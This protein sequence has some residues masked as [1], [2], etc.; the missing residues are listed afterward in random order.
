MFLRLLLSLLV[1]C[2]I[3]LPQDA[4]AAT[5]KK[6][7][8]TTKT[9]QTVKKKSASSSSSGKYRKIGD[10][11]MGA[12]V[13]APDNQVFLNVAGF[14]Y[15][16]PTIGYEHALG[17][18]NSWTGQVGYRSWGGTGFSLNYLGVLGSYRWYLG[19]HAK[20]QGFY[21]GPLGTVQMVNASYDA[22]TI[23]GFTVTTKKESTSS[24]IF[25]VGGEGGYQWILPMGL[26]FSG[27]LNA[28]YYFGTI[29][30]VSGAPSFSVGGFGAGL[31]GTIG[32]AF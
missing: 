1:S 18:D 28:G 12:F 29:N 32:Y 5:K 15:G 9:S 16:M 25:G 23:S 17:K 31:N 21:A 27:G 8:K 3:L 6:S 30:L 19:D 4:M 14:L 13:A 26:T 10:G 2:A 24:F 20:M 7:K 22:T 11:P